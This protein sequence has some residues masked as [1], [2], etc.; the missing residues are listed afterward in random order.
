MIDF[1]PVLR[2]V[3]GLIFEDGPFT[4]AVVAWVTF[5]GLTLTHLVSAALQPLVLVL[6]FVAVLLA[7]IWYTAKRKK[8]LS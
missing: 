2:E 4:I 6:G 1:K 3:F 5:A 7:S 8:D